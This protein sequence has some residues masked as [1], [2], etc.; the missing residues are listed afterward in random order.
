M[1]FLALWGEERLGQFAGLGEQVMER[2][3]PSS[4]NPQQKYLINS[5]AINHRSP[6]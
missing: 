4:E 6:E 5:K 1:F 3:Q 2:L